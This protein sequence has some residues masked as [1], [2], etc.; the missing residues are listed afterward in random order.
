VLIILGGLLVPAE[1][2]QAPPPKK[3]E[4]KAPPALVRKDLLA[5]V[6][7]ELVPPRRNIFTGRGAGA[8]FPASQEVRREQ[9]ALEE[10]NPFSEAQSEDSALDI[11]YIGYVQ[12]GKRV[13]GLVVFA[14]EVFAVEPGDVLAPGMT[15]STIDPQSIEVS[16]PDSQSVK[17][18]LEGEEP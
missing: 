7:R 11:R 17:V 4:K 16:L 18:K 12:S 9:G 2:R 5:G 8:S 14:G 15:V 6:P 13:V 10:Q 3:A 1:A